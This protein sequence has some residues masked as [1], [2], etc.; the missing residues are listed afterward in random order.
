MWRHPWAP[1]G[2]QLYT[3]WEKAESKAKEEIS[4]MVFN[5]FI[6]CQVSPQLWPI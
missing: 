2:L 4:S 3:D 6:W 5:T 1:F